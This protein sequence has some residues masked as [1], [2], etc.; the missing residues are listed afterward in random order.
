MA[1]TTLSSLL[2][3]LRGLINDGGTAVFT[4]DALQRHLDNHRYDIRHEPLTP[5]P[6]WTG[7]GSV[8]YYDYRSRYGDYETTQAGTAIFVIEDGV[9]TNVGTAAWANVDYQ[10]GIITFTTD[11][12]GTAL[13]LSGRSYDMYGA[14][15]DVLDDWSQKVALEF[16]FSSDQ[17]S[18]TR[19]QKQA[20]LKTAA[21]GYRRKAKPRTAKITRGDIA[22]SGEK[23][24]RWDEVT[25]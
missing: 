12:A 15:A 2:S 23:A 19:S 25:W 20:M 14:A 17:Q 5:L 11:Y 16:D 7:G 18:F 4:D 21:E 8:S 13:Y 3:T 6:T 9:G 1:R 22:G 10:L 24:R